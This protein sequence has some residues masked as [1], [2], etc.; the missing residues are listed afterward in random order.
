MTNVPGPRETR[1]LAGKPIRGIMFWVP[2]SGRLGLGLSILSYAG[3]VLVGIAADAGL[4]PEPQAIVEALHDE[5][6]S[7]MELVRQAQ[8]A[9]AEMA[10]SSQA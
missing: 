1:Y 2:Q 6:E 7:M 8:E 3:E 5:V 9:D 4:T 10:A